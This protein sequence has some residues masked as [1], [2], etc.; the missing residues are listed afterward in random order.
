M[1]EP[2]MSSSSTYMNTPR[3][4]TS[5]VRPANSCLLSS[6]NLTEIGK[7]SEKRRVDLCSDCG[8]VMAALQLQFCVALILTHVALVTEPESSSATTGPNPSAR[9]PDET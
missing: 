2:A 5:R 4:L 3:E 6:R 1:G 7:S 9:S 8:D